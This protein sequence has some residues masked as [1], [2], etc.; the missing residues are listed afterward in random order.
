VANGDII[1]SSGRAL[2][3]LLLD[4]ADGTQLNNGAWVDCGAYGVG[5]VAVDGVA[6]AA[7]LTVYGSNAAARPSNATN[8][9]AINVSG[10]PTT[11][12]ANPTLV[13]AALPRWIKVGITT[14]GTGTI[15]VTFT[16]RVS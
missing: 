4:A 7:V 1:A 6:T 10:N 8:T 9:G 11:A 15:T 12:G 14:V 2:A 5:T 16:A 13:L 3:A